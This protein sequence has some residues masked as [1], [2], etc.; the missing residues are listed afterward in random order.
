MLKHLNDYIMKTKQH[1]LPII[2]ILLLMYSCKKDESPQPAKPYDQVIYNFE[3]VDASGGIGM[4]GFL[5]SAQIDSGG[6]YTLFK[7]VDMPTELTPMHK[8]KGKFEILPETYTCKDGRPD[9]LPGHD[10]PTVHP[11]F[12]N[13]LSWANNN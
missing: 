8:Y 12:V 9:P 13:I 2:F 11:H 4:C 5:I 1:F 7:G 3:I 6:S 10:L